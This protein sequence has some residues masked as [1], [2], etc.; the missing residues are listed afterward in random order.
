MHDM[1]EMLS[2]EI[3]KEIAD[4]YFG[5]RKMIEDDSREY[6][7]HVLDAFRQLENEVGFD[8]V[9]LYILLNREPLIYDFFRLTGLRD[10]IFLDPYLLQSASI[11]RRLFRGQ[12][13]H[14]FTRRSRFQN[15]FFD[16]YNRLCEG[17]EH[18]GATLKRLVAEGRAI[19]EEIEVFHRKND[20]GSM[21]GF[22]RR[23]DS[24]AMHESGAMA[25][26]LNPQRDSA[27]EDKMRITAPQGAET[28][29]PA[30]P[31]LPPLKTCKSQ[32]RDLLDAAYAA[33]GQPEVQL[34]GR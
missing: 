16:I 6:D 17:M 34:F 25:G 10:P 26:G 11:R 8:L 27:L 28:L 14:G 21:M 5:F 30:F 15:L 3:K 31:P 12:A 20:L 23:L 22:L 24:G 18:Y 4:R 7:Q 2:L 33:Q 13:V 29:L 9:R 32:L 1:E 19:A